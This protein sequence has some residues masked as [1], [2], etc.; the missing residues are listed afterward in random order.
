MIENVL[1]VGDQVTIMI[2]KGDRMSGATPFPDGTVATVVGFNEIAYGRLLNFGLDPGIYHNTS[3]PNLLLED[4][5]ERTEFFRR[6]E[7]IDQDEYNR[8]V[9]E[10]RSAITSPRDWRVRMKRIRP[11][12]DTPYWEGDLVR[13]HDRSQT[14]DAWAELPPKPFPE[15][16]II[17]YIHYLG[18]A[19]SAYGKKFPPPVYVMSDKFSSR[20]SMLACEDNVELVVRGDVWKYYHHEPLVFSNLYEEANFFIMLD[21][22]E[23]VPN[24]ANNL[25]LW[26]EGEALEAVSKGIAH[27][28]VFRGDLFG[29]DRRISAIK[30]RD[31]GLGL[32]VAEATLS[33]SNVS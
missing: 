24:P 33:S 28:Y 9:N 3:R 1:Q 15:V 22:F 32:R 4:G 2:G 23:E 21:H 11:L 16:Y 12:P 29:P 19:T 8:R 26:T 6:L 10:R 14:I 17:I 25:Y 20:W 18:L 27:G 31:E 30:F 7:M 13:I 5:R